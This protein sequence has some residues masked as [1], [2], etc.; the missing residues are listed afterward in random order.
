M[1]TAEGLCW[2]T[3][4]LFAGLL[5]GGAIAAAAMSVAMTIYSLCFLMAAS[6]MIAACTRCHPSVF[7]FQA[8]ACNRCHVSWGIS[9][10][11]RK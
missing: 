5:P 6:F 4:T 7:L 3:M 2:G 8:I 1:D 11:P 10:P 9:C